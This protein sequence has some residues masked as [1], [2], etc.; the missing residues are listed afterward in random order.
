MTTDT[1]QVQLVTRSTSSGYSH[2]HGT[3]PVVGTRKSFSVCSL[4]TVREVR[5]HIKSS[6]IAEQVHTQFFTRNHSLDAGNFSVLP[7]LPFS[8]RRNFCMHHLVRTDYSRLFSVVCRRK[9]FALHDRSS[10]DT[11]AWFAIF[12]LPSTVFR[13]TTTK[14]FRFGYVLH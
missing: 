12:N 1:V 11:T 9:H 10:R 5:L 8:S 4:S 3:L 2:V 14:P 7:L 6:P 13:I